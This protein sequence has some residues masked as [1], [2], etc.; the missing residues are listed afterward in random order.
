[1]VEGG[2]LPLLVTP[3]A[4]GA[5]TVNPV[6]LEE[7]LDEHRGQ[8][9]E[10]LVEHGGILFRGF[11]IA[12]ADRFHAVAAACSKELMVYKERS[13]PRTLV[14]EHVYTSTDY[15]SDQGIFPHNEHSYAIC[16]PTRIAFFCLVPPAAGGETPLVDC[17][18]VLARIPDEVRRR[19]IDRGGWR[20]VR[21]FNEGVGLPWQTVYQTTDREAVEEY[22]RQNEIQCIW[23][24]GGRLRTVQVRT[25]VARHPMTGV[26]IWFNHATFFNIGTLP[27]L[28]RD[29]L[30]Q[31]FAVDDLPNNTYYGDGAPF[32]PET[33]AVLHGAYMAEQIAF[34]WERGDVLLLDNM[35]TA[36]GRN[37]F[38]GPRQILVS[39][40]DPV[41]RR[42]L[43]S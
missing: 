7:W 40:A 21:T 14:Q 43:P 13:S 15:P 5:D 23:G 4:V 2:R 41:E 39:M 8:V 22:C 29:G 37:P 31:L 36:H 12:S 18:R 33:L 20:Y 28:L 9:D 11:G 34:P 30:L 16:F 25:V 10:W 32:E 27:P 26:E 6:N 35:L 17:R 38:E 19:F 42:A 1:L 3:S 24:A